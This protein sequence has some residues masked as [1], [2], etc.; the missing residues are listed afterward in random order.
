MRPMLAA[1]V[2]LPLGVVAGCGLPELLIDEQKPKAAPAA[3]QPANSWILVEKGDVPKE[4]PCAG[5]GGTPTSAAPARPP[6]CRGSPCC[7]RTL[8]RQLPSWPDRTHDGQA[9][10]RHSDRDVVSPRRRLRGDLPTHLQGNPRLSSAG[11][12]RQEKQA[13]SA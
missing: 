11:P 8:R 7:K 10:S 6:A 3:E 2:L 5:A 9:R 13:M 1:T 12:V 4:E